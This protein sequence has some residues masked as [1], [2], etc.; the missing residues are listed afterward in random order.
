MPATTRAYDVVVLGATG[1]SGRKVCIHL[2]KVADKYKWAIAGRDPKKLEALTK[3]LSLGPEVGVLVADTSN[4]VALDALCSNTT[5]V[6]A[7]A[8]P[9]DRVGLPVVDACVRNKTHYCDIT[10]EFQFFRKVIEKYDTVAAQDKVMLVPCCGF[11]CVP[12]D[13]G[14]WL[15]HESAKAQN[16]DI[17]SVVGYFQGSGSPS[18]GTMASFANLFE[19]IE[20]KDF[21]PSSLNPTNAPKVPTPRTTWISYAKDIGRWAGPYIMSG[22]NE[23]VV[24]RSNALNNKVASYVE[25]SV[26]SLPSVVTGTLGLILFGVLIGTAPLRSLLVRYVFPAPGTGPSDEQLKSGFF[27]ATFVGKT[28][29]GER[30][31]VLVKDSRD[32]YT[33]TGVFA[34]SCG[35]VAADLARRN[36]VT[37]GGVLTSSSAFGTDLVDRLR[38][39]GMTFEL[40]SKDSNKKRN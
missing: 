34:A 9:F 23:R 32:A 1:Y 2:A 14:N 30:V 17:K 39:A 18:G 26:G 20:R 33:A 38:E 3:D 21:S 28:A 22:I 24:R 40:L 10:G 19:T 16:L 37:T 8:G 7:C 31:D 13:L 29:T 27:K 36:A 5:V 6:I 4:S 15:V 11:D 25:A 35:L 12:S